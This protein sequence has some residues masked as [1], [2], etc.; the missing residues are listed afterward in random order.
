MDKKILISLF[1]GLE[2]YRRQEA[3]LSAEKL[4]I[5]ID[6]YKKYQKKRKVINDKRV[7]ISKSELESLNV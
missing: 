5:A 3:K 6:A 2:K 1:D 7:Y 4:T